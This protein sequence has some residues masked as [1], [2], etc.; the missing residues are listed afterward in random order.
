M[1]DK[2]DD[3]DSPKPTDLDV[4]STPGSWDDKSATL[5]IEVDRG[6]KPH[7][8]DVPVLVVVAGQASGQVFNVLPGR[9]IIGRAKTVEIL[10]RDESISRRHAEL[11]WQVGGL[12]QIRDLGS[13]N[14]VWVN[15]NKVEEQGLREGDMIRIGEDVTLVLEYR[16]EPEVDR[17]RLLTSDKLHDDV[18]GLFSREYLEAHLRSDLSLARRHT[19]DIGVLMV[20]VDQLGE[21]NDTHGYAAG[22]GILQEVARLLQRRIRADDILARYGGDEFVVVLRR[23]DKEG[24]VTLANSL[25]TIFNQTPVVFHGVQM[26]CT[27]T[28]GVACFPAPITDIH[29]ETII[30]KCQKAIERGK[31][32][33]GDCVE[34]ESA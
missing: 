3:I 20:D 17:H 18:T 10:I 22:N 11:E 8:P 32:K 1:A 14:G 24:V 30:M 28:I 33:G 15:D 21:I 7:L 34:I 19:E 31:A 27:I 2:K 25:R 4:E 29:P 26:E 5:Q 12:L 16:V 6:G 9:M 13:T 23:T